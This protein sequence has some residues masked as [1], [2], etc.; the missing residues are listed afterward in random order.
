MHNQDELY[1]LKERFESKS[2]L[3]DL[4]TEIRERTNEKILVFKIANPTD[5]FF[6]IL[7][8]I[9]DELS[10]QGEHSHLATL[11]KT[12]KSNL[13]Q[14]AEGRL[15]L[16]TL[17]E[18]L[19]INRYS[20]K[21]DFFARY[22]KSVSSAEEQVTASANHIV[23]GRRGAGKSTLLLYAMHKRE[24][25]NL[26]QAW[27]DM[28]V[29]A[30]RYDDGVIV[31]LLREIITQSYSFLPTPNTTSEILAKLEEIENADTIDEPKIIKLLPAIRRYLSGFATSGR[32]LFI[33]LDDFH[34]IDPAIQ[35]KVLNVI[36]AIARGNQIY[37]KLSAI[38][39]LTRTFEPAERI[40]IEV[41]HDAQLIRLDLNLTMPD[42]AANHIQS[43]LDAHAI[44]CGLP[45]IRRLCTSSDVIYRLTWVAAGV[46]RD[47]LSL[48]SQAMTK[49]ALSGR[50]RVSVSNINVAASETIS[51]KLKDLDSDASKKAK[52]LKS[53]LEDIREFT[54]K[55]SRKNAF[56]VEIKGDSDIY[57]K[58]MLLVDLRLLHVISEGITVGEAGRK[59]LGLI[60]D[61]GFYVGIRAAQSVDLFNKQTGRVAY[62]QL[63]G[64]P[65]FMQDDI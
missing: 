46:P 52:E 7:E 18:S 17:S 6:R 29:F 23:Y 65:V 10:K 53:L 9:R 3:I 61:Y 59:F 4:D 63:R 37:L 15:L 24:A 28:Q 49:A 45:S 27:I 30:K 8:D 48:F 41:P 54:I 21:D 5:R 14:S 40:G 51:T 34:V 39:T 13:L 50:N 11:K 42:K 44:Y 60:L 20:F 33:F 2:G 62:K 57:Q 58:V 64:L 12:N 31:E 26:P 19:N 1:T 32:D 22:T 56:L 35:P 25:E 43:I 38:E 47:A 55:Q 16:R 36:Y